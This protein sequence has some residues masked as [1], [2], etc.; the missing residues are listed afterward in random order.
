LPSSSLFRILAT[1][2]IVNTVLL[3]NDTAHSTSAFFSACLSPGLLT[4]RLNI[5]R[6]NWMIDHHAQLGTG[7][8]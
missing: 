6:P 3:V 2:D 8:V 4:L 7:H 5:E 1:D